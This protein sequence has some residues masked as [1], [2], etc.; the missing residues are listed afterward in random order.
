MN[1]PECTKLEA[2]MAIPDLMT[3]RLILRGPTPKDFP[4]YE[5]FFADDRASA[6]YGGPL[7]ATDAWRVLSAESEP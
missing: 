3:D 1:F 4:V 5:R 2:K 6:A 7:K